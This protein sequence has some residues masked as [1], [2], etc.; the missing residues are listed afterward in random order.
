MVLQLQYS[1]STLLSSWLNKI[2]FQST[3]FLVDT[4][5]YSH[6]IS[7]RIATPTFRPISLR[8][9]IMAF[10]LWEHFKAKHHTLLHRLCTSGNV[11]VGH[12]SKGLIAWFFYWDGRSPRACLYFGTQ[13][14]PVD[15]LFQMEPLHKPVG[16]IG[17]ITKSPAHKKR[18]RLFWPCL[19]PLKAK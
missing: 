12:S 11:T 9:Y 2:R 8:K 1:S 3:F 13:S 16:V 14:V 5:I 4:P 18:R 15:T 6:R 7:I 19:H 17:S 10:P